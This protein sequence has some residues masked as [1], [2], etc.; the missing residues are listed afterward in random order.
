MHVERKVLRQDT[1]REL[2]VVEAEKLE[3]IDLFRSFFTNIIG[4]QP[5]EDTE[6]LFTEM[7]QELLDE[8]R[9]TVK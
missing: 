7:L 6:R 3:D 9:E 5:D 8:E 2:Q 1:S 4:V